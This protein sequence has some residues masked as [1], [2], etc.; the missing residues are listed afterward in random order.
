MSFLSLLGSAGKLLSIRVTIPVWLIIAA[1]FWVQYDKSSVVRKAIAELVAGAELEAERARVTAK[2]Q[3][4]QT[5]EQKAAL[6]TKANE[7][8]NSE[9][10]EAR[11]SLEDAD[12]QIQELLSS[13]VNST[14]TVDSRVFDRLQNK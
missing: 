9:L 13:P 10:Q 1:G 6:L 14:C 4:I 5:L 11:T 7:N 2:D 12:D 8:F 3:I